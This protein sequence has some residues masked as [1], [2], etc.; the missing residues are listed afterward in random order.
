[1]TGE[2]LTASL[3]LLLVSLSALSVAAYLGNAHR[4]FELASHFR[5]QYLAFAVLFVALFAA[6]RELR[7]ATLSLALAALNGY[8]LIPATLPTAVA[9]DTRV[10]VDKATSVR[11]LLANLQFSNNAH[12]A[13]ANLVRTR[14]PDV[15]VVQEVTPAWASVL[16]PL[17]KDFPAGKLIAREGAFGIGILSRWPIREIR[18]LDF[19]QP[20]Y[21]ALLAHIQTDA[22]PFALLAAHPPPPTS[23]AGFAAR[24]SQLRRAAV[25][26]RELGPG[27]VLLGDLNTSPWSPHFSALLHKSGM[28]NARE[29]FG[30]LPTWP[31]F[32]PPAMI[33]IDHCLVSDDARVTD[34]QTGPSIGSD[35]LP[36]IID[37]LVQTS[38]RY[39]VLSA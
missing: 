38:P 12:Q 36:L 3:K 2:H 35:H 29:G 9:A 19:G 17:R 34:I 8:A 37:L 32:F 31:S 1:M 21:P 20:R 6:R 10:T 4:L 7:W 27:S 26:L 24:N 39:T 5:P 30:L 25:L 16:T 13:F 33:P 15:I 28:R 14:Q 11:L 23:E 18:Q 22:N